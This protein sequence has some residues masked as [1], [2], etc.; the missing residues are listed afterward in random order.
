MGGEVRR[1]RDRIEVERGWKVEREEE[2]REIRG[3]VRIRPLR[4]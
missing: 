2:K 1:E 3:K 4:R